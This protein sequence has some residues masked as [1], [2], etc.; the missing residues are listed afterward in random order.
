M[1]SL[2][3]VGLGSLQTHAQN[4]TAEQL[5]VDYQDANQNA[6]AASNN[7]NTQVDAAEDINQQ[8]EKSKKTL[9]A[10]TVATFETL[11][12]VGVGLWAGSVPTLFVAG[13]GQVIPTAKM[14]RDWLDDGNLDALKVLAD[15][16]VSHA[17]KEAIETER[18]DDRSSE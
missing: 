13:I 11:F 4:K 5:W 9:D 14:V 18:N 17:H 10:A 3:F 16:A 7:Y 15:Q 1:C 8:I 2:F 6:S 12:K